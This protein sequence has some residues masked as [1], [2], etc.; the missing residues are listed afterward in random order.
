MRIL[1]AVSA[2]IDSMYMAMRRSEL[3]PFGSSFAVAH[4]NFSL[5]GSE[6]DG[7]EAFVRSWCAAQGLQLFVKRFDTSAYAAARGISIEMAARDL[8]Y[9]WFAQLLDSEGFDALAVAHNSN[10]NAET[11]LLN[12]LRGTGSRGLRGMGERPGL[13][14]PLLG[15]SRAEIRSWML[16]Q[17]AAWREDST[18]AQSDCKRNI[19]RNELFPLFA[20]INPSFVR[21]LNEDMARF[22]QVDEIA[23]DYYLSCL[24]AL[25][26]P[27]GEVLIEPLLATKHWEYLLWR[28][29][30][31]CDISGDEFASLVACLKSGRQIAGKRFGSVLGTSGSLQIVGSVRARA[32]RSELIDRSELASLKAGRGVLLMDA[33]VLGSDWSVRAWQPGDWL[34]PLGMRGKKKLSDLMTGLKWSLEQK[35]A[36]RVLELDGSH[37]GALLCE[38]IDDSL[39]VSSATTRVLRLW[40]E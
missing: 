38:R 1:L 31:A 10:D 37:V 16:E 29:L 18:N 17:G 20:R 28:L 11:L 9:E 40:Y 4:C 30:E 7:D 32:L 21:T 15:T 8:R 35:G 39:K 14:R 5:R 13:L 22:A 3:F 25:R 27:E 33:D 6:S 34:R 12:L 19:I 24:P 2:G 23:Q 26:G 36:A